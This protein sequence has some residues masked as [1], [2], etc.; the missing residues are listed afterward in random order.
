MNEY[1]RRFLERAKAEK[2]RFIEAL[3]NSAAEQAAMR[4]AFV[5]DNVDTAFGREHGFSKIQ[6]FDDFRHA[7]PVR[8]FEELSPWI[9]RVVAGE[10][11]VLTADEPILFYVTTGTT[12]KPKKIP[13]TRQY[14]QRFSDCL[15]VYWAGLSE[16]FPAILER[17]D[18]IVMLHLAPKPYT[19]TTATGIPMLNPTHVPSG[20]KGAFPYSRAPWFPPPAELNDGERLYYLLR[21][22]I[23]SPL[24][25]FVCLHPSR[26]Q[27]IVSRL[28]EEGPRLVD[29]LER[30]TVCG[31]PVGAPNPERANEIA[32]I[33]REGTLLPRHVWPT[34][35]FV[36]CWAGGSFKMYLP[37]I[38]ESFGAD[39]YPQM[40]A[41]SEAGQFTMPLDRESEPIDGPLAVRTCFFEF[42]E[43]SGGLAEDGGDRARRGDHTLLLEQLEPGKTYEM[44]VTTCAGLY[45]YANGDRFEVRGYVHGVPRLEFVGRGGIVDMTGEKISEQQIVAAVERS[46][47]ALGLETKNATCCPV[48]GRPSHYTFVFE[49]GESWAPA[50]LERLR[51]HL[52]RELLALNPRYKLKRDFGDLG[53]P[54]V[55]TVKRGTFARYRERLVASGVPG[56]QIKDKVL[57]HDNAVLAAFRELEA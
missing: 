22:S 40:S 35:E 12:G 42:L 52:D 1:R 10:S 6:T 5:G 16:H 55:Q 20:G 11:N 45:R 47:A 32:R 21:R 50:V 7:V 53:P 24:R 23:E 25:G 9:D 54:A 31:K 28:H 39:V 17:D 19:E 30:G 49:P 14:F 38:R 57:H 13:V 2:Q 56:T 18:T 41:S 27:A 36:S 51:E 37:E 44:I 43:V 15:L 3:K 29:E 26:L 33:L 46:L 48:L 4:T 8:S 34:L